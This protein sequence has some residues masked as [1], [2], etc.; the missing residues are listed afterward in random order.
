MAAGN[1]TSRDLNITGNILM[2]GVGTGLKLTNGVDITLAAGSS[3]T[4]SDVINLGTTLNFGTITA[5]ND[6]A[7]S[8]GSA[9]QILTVN[10]AGTGV[11]WGTLPAPSTPNIQQVLTAG[12]IATAVGISFVGASATTFDSTANITSA[13]Q[14]FGQNNTFSATGSAAGT[15][16]IA[17]TG[18]LYDG[19]S[20]GTSGQVLTSTGSGVAWASTAGVTS[21]TAQTPAT[22]SGTPITISPTSGAVQVTSN[23]CWRIKC[24]S[25]ASRRYSRNIPSGRWNMG[26]QRWRIC[27]D[28]QVLQ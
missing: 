20:V 19:A 27:S 13:E 8:T 4:S 9:G 18:T 16:G 23:A 15:A 24:W 14:M 17:L 7:G 12:N 11:E 1:A 3:I 10:A 25:C 26:R 6:Y 22:S 28:L 21:V 5:I 2:S